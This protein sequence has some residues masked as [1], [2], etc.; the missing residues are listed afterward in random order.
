[1]NSYVPRLLSTRTRSANIDL[2]IV[3][4]DPFN[5]FIRAR[6]NPDRIATFDAKSCR[7]R[8]LEPTHR[9]RHPDKAS[10][11]PRD[12]LTFASLGC[13]ISLP[14]MCSFFRRTPEVLYPH[15]KGTVPCCWR[16]GEGPLHTWRREYLGILPWWLCRQ[17]STACPSSRPSPGTHPQSL[18]VQWK[19]WGTLPI[20]HTELRPGHWSQEIKFTIE[21]A[22]WMSVCSFCSLLEHLQWNLSKATGHVTFKMWSLCAGGLLTHTASVMCHLPCMLSRSR[23]FRCKG[24]SPAPGIRRL[25]VP[26][27]CFLPVE[28][29]WPFPRPR[30][31]P[32][33][34]GSPCG[35]RDGFYPL[36]SSHR[37]T[38][39]PS[40]STPEGKEKTKDYPWSKISPPL[41]NMPKQY[42]QFAYTCR[43]NEK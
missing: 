24:Y 21:L 5:G 36:E 35:F 15:G 25:P 28:Y 3:Y 30:C 39:P 20:C 10:S 13:R 9:C 26:E 17:Q 41:C 12:G 14:Y 4:A 11:L 16:P 34:E 43:A 23:W 29:T 31:I 18:A 22:N 19:Q 33:A 2:C 6:S 1:M 27:S 42:T 32:S 40:Y 8:H 7:C 37:H 38:F